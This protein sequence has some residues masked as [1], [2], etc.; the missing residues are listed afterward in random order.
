MFIK[1]WTYKHITQKNIHEKY[2]LSSMCICNWCT[3]AKKSTM[4]IF[5]KI[6]FQNPFFFKKKKG[7]YYQ[8][9]MNK[10][11]IWYTIMSDMSEIQVHSR[12]VQGSN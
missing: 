10:Q 5:L 8:N 6:S 2:Q 1:Q 3:G 7:E 12:M 11:C 4:K 9:W